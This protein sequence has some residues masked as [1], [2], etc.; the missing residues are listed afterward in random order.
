MG[1]KVRTDPCTSAAAGLT[2]LE[3]PDTTG[4]DQ[5]LHRHFQIEVS[6]GVQCQTGTL[7]AFNRPIFAGPWR[8]TGNCNLAYSRAM[9]A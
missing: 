9:P 2:L 5:A 1:A 3:A 7:N 4:S 8:E 6:V